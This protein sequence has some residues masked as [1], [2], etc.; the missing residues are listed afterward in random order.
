[1]IR[2]KA[3]DRQNIQAVCGLT[4]DRDDVPA[5][6]HSYRNA[7][8]IAEA[9]YDPEMH[10]NAIYNNQVLIGFFM[11]KRPERHAQTAAMCRFMID[12]RFHHKGF[13]EKALEHILRGLRIQGVRKVILMTDDADKIAEN[14]SLS[15]GFCFTGKTDENGRHYYEFEL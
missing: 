11:Y 12:D 13:E 9:G 7:L 15:S 2:I 8:S 4:T 10:F 6:R 3:V 1:M 14:L 5:E